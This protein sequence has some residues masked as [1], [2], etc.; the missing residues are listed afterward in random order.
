MWSGCIWVFAALNSFCHF[1]QM[2]IKWRNPEA[3]I[4]FPKASEE[5]SEE[6]PIRYD[7]LAANEHDWCAG[8]I[9]DLN[10]QSA[11]AKSI[12]CIGAIYRLVHKIFYLHSDGFEFVVRF[13]TSFQSQLHLLGWASWTGPLRP[14]VARTTVG[15]DCGHQPLSLNI[16]E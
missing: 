7:E 4:F 14:L 15:G 16:E 8:L 6:V 10:S 9:S 1:K 11:G 13:R 2:L 3:N 5:T 12:I